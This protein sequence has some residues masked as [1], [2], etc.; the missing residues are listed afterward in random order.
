MYET[1]TSEPAR[2]T[3]IAEWTSRP[4]F[5]GYGGNA[6]NSTITSN[7]SVVVAAHLRNVHEAVCTVY[8]ESVLYVTQSVVF[9]GER[10]LER[11]C[12]WRARVTLDQQIGKSLS[13]LSNPTVNI[14]LAGINHPTQVIVVS[15]KI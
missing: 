9:I 14:S 2:F 6:K 4:K 5:R 10:S 12:W 1:S 11:G 13:A 3:V 15:W 7:N 8:L